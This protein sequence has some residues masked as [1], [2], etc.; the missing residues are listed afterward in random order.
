MWALGRT[1]LQIGKAIVTSTI[2]LVCQYL[3]FTVA[4]YT[5]VYNFGLLLSVG[6]GSAL[7]FD[8]FLLPALVLV[9]HRPR[10]QQQMVA[11]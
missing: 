8:L 3:I 4:T 10:R 2:V 5:P 7:W 6:I 9:S 11:A 1:Y